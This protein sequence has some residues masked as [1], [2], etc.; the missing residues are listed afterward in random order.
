MLDA[1]ARANAGAEGLDG[2][3]TR[4][5]GTGSARTSEIDRSLDGNSDSSGGS[6]YNGGATTAYES[7]TEDE[8]DSGNEVSDMEW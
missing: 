7:G 3:S 5:G 2:N 1:Y 8:S 6:S 4:Y